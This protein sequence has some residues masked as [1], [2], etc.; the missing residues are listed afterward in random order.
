MLSERRAFGAGK[1]ERSSCT[2]RGSPGE[3]PSY[4]GRALKALGLRIHCC[5]LARGRVTG[6]PEMGLMNSRCVL[7]ACVALS[8]CGSSV[9]TSPDVSTFEQQLAAATAA[10][11]SYQAATQTMSTAA[12]CGAAVNGY[13]GPM[14]D[15]LGHMMSTSG[16]MD[17]H[18]RS[19]GEPARADVTCGLQG[20]DDELRQHLQVACHSGDMAQ[21]RAEAA[22]HVAAMANSLQHMQMRAA[23]VSAGTGHGMGPGMMDGG[24]R[25]PDGGVMDPDDHPMGCLGGPSFDGGMPHGGDPGPM[26]DG[27][28]MH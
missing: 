17:D 1:L 24:W 14:Q 2:R 22:R 4:E 18:M 21:N 5:S 16:A 9:S 7:A 11:S 13:A 28:V 3:K 25:M 12:I 19:M 27:G 15:D 20:M 26:M 8:G 10:L 6:R 23:E